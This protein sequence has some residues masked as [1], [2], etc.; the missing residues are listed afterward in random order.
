METMLARALSEIR[1]SRRISSNVDVEVERCVKI[2]DRTV[3]D[4]EEIVVQEDGEVVL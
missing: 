2:G 1:L 3:V 4:V